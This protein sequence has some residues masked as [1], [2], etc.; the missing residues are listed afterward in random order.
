LKRKRTRKEETQYN[1]EN[2]KKFRGV[3]NK[4]NILFEGETQ[5]HPHGVREKRSEGE[6]EWRVVGR[7]HFHDES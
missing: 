7:A 6:T 4:V 3:K 5:T 2:T 1:A